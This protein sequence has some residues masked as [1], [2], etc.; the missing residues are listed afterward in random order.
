MPTL[1]M[2]PATMVFL[3]LPVVLRGAF[4][5]ARRRA[6][7]VGSARSVPARIAACT[8]RRRIPTLD[9]LDR[10]DPL[11]LVALIHLFLPLQLLW[12]S[13]EEGVHHDGAVLLRPSSHR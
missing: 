1:R 10:G 13:P 4:C 5:L 7:I 6:P 2:P 3:R 8:A 9:G 11:L 12:V